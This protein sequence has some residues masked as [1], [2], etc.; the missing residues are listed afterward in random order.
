MLKLCLETLKS[1][2]GHQI[3]DKKSVLH[4]LDL[5]DALAKTLKSVRPPN[6]PRYMTLIANISCY[7]LVSLLRHLVVLGGPLQEAL[8][9]VKVRY[10]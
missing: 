2:K 1:H 3:K 9:L 5:R 7:L 8:V 6:S 10:S 4:G